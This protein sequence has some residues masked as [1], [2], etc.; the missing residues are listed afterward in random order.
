MNLTELQATLDQHCLDMKREMPGF[1]F[2]GIFNC[3][4]GS[5]ICST[6]MDTNPL[7]A[8]IEGGAAFHAQIVAQ[9]DNIVN[10]STTAQVNIDFIQI[11]SDKITYILVISELRKFFSITAL[12]RST[13]N[14]GLSKMLLSKCRAEYGPVLDS[15]F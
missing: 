12:D 1:L 3:K 11:E 7:A 10:A 2:Y 8:D 5:K 6:K 9:V 14:L 13:Q 15:V 4:D